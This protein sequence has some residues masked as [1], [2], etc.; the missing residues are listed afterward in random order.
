MR[1]LVLVAG[2][3]AMSPNISFAGGTLQANEISKTVI[4]KVAVRP[5]DLPEAVK[6]ALSSNYSEWKVSSAYLVTKEDNSQ[7]YEVNLKKTEESTTVN[8]D[9]YGKKL[10]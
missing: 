5:E 2:L 7:Y 6:S 8:L 10:D 3:L 9:K 4:D 1:N